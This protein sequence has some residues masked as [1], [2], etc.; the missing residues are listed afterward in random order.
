[1][2]YNFVQNF[3]IK[4][5]KKIV[6]SF[7]KEWSIDQDRQKNIDSHSKTK[8]YNIYKKEINY[9]KPGM[10]YKKYLVSDNKKLIKYV[11]KIVSKLEKK[12]D[13]KV[14]QCVLALLPAG[15]MIPLHRDNGAYLVVSRR[16]HIP[17]I[18]NGN[19]LFYIN[20][21]L[22]VMQ[23]GECWEINNNKSHCVINAGKN[24]RIHL[25]IDIIPNSQI[26][27]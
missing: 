6:S 3:N 17:I 8:S 26:G 5:I 1:M 16:H 11:D 18:T 19:V 15:E 9:W 23:E 25:I 20:D 27:H 24:D 7:D 21:E 14:G 4:K 10:E 22:K 12:C 2:N 13:G